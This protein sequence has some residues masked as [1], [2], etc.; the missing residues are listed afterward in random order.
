MAIY[1]I[2]GKPGNGKS[3]VAVDRAINEYLRN[4]RRVVSN[5]HFDV[6]PI[7]KRRNGHLAHADI[8]VIP[9]VPTLEQFKGIGTGG[10][11]EQEAGLLILDECGQF[12][13]SRAWQAEDRQK[14]IE[15][16]LQ[17]RKYY[18]DVLLVVQDH[19]LLDKQIRDAVVEMV[20]RCRRSDRKKFFGVSM[21]RMHICVLRYGTNPND[22]I[23]DRWVYRGADAHKCFDSY[24]L[25][26]PDEVQGR[27]SVIPPRLS[28]WR[29]IPKPDP[30]PTRFL[31]HALRSLVYVSAQITNTPS[32]RIPLLAAPG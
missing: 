3:T 32:S 18:W 12:L 20:G 6:A 17:S 22:M 26:K 23:V 5:F 31:N 4:G 9:A 27:Y 24:A 7:C 21:P 10:R 2:T 28:K 8:E 11:S 14:F 25:F 13:N 1:C 16:F 30:I 19:N 29:Y 15:F